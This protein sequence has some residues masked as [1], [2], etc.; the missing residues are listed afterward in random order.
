VQRDL[1]PVE[2]A[3]E[4]TL[5]PMPPGQQP[6]EGEVAGLAL[7]DP[8]EA[9]AQGGGTPAAGLA[10]VGLQVTLEPPE[11]VPAQAGIRAR[12]SST[13]RRCSAVAGSAILISY[14]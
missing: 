8:V 5:A 7:E 9:G 10:P 4:F 1:R 12:T 6:V 2:H 13:A 14:A 11:P 3:Q